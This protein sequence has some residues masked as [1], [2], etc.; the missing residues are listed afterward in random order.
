MMTDKPVSSGFIELKGV[1]LWHEVYGQGEPLLVL[2]GGL[3]TIPDMMT[4]I[5]PLAKRRRVIGLELQGHGRTIDTDRP[6]TLETMGDDVAAAIA[7]LGLRHADV[8]GHS[9][10]A[11]SALRAAIQ[12]PSA[13]RKLIV[14]SSV[15]ARQ[16]WYPETRQGMGAVNGDMAESLKQMPVGRFAAK[17]P[18]P[19]RFAKFLD[20]FGKMMGQDYDWSNDIPKLPM[21]VQLIFAD[22]DAIAQKHIAEFFA[23]LGGGISEPGWQ[24]TK[25]T[26]A[27]LAVVPGYSH[28]DLD[29]SSEVPEIV[30][31]F[32]SDSRFASAPR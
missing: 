25:F 20:K 7:A 31:R 21:P 3:R 24:N 30:E 28:Y 12:H 10:G 18:Q 32:L 29:T 4:W 9:F 27:R 26:R 11:A 19:E 23:L 13:V 1:K 22:H 2:H 16:G 6:I 15:F 5:G 14:I 17:W 8:A